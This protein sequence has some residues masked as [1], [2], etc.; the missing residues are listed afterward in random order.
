MEERVRGKIVDRYVEE[1]ERKFHRE[2]ERVRGKNQTLNFFNLHTL[3]EP[4]YKTT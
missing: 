3:R 1:R 2:R 4:F